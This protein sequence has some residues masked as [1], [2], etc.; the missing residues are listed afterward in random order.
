M[1][2]I[3]MGCFFF[4]I[5]LLS[6]FPLFGTSPSLSHSQLPAP[7]YKISKGGWQRLND[8]KISKRAEFVF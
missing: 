7:R 6:A 3:E 2:Q 1:Q 5:F 8:E 4:L